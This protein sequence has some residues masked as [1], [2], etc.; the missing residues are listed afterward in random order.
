MLPI[1]IHYIRPT[2]VNYMSNLEVKKEKPFAYNN[3][4]TFLQNNHV[5]NKVSVNRTPF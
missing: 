1:T 3:E 4:T 5:L 2:S